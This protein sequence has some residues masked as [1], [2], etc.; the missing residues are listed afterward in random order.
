M[1][2]VK[3]IIV[4]RKDLKMRKGKIASQSSHASMKIILD[5]MTETTIV[6][7]IGKEVPNYTRTLTLDRMDPLHKWLEGSFTKVVVY[8][9][10]KE[11]LLEIEAKAKES[12]IRTALIVDSGKTEFHGVPTTT[13]L[14]LG[15]DF[16]DKLNKVTGHL[17]L[18]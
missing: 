16:A 18:L 6:H 15:P 17:K 13:C 14:A 10:S 9:N 1:E 7:P 5:L 4:V 12:G 11:E 3:Q 8:V 2:D